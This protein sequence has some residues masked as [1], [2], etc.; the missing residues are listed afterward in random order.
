MAVLPH[1][2]RVRRVHYRVGARV[3][4][5]SVAGVG[6]DATR[7]VEAGEDR[8]NRL[9]PWRWAVVIG[10]LAANTAYLRYATAPPAATPDRQT[11]EQLPTHVA[12]WAGTSVPLDWRIREALKLD[13]Y[14]N[15]DYVSAPNVPISL[16]V[17]YY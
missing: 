7:L 15:R 2:L 16:Y 5:A 17:G 13:D 3:L 8:V 10:C 9:T 12:G 14:V 6:H 4:V 11:L 1:V